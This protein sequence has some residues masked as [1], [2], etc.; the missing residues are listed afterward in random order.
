MWNMHP[1]WRKHSHRGSE[2]FW[3][4]TVWSSD[5]NFDRTTF[6][7]TYRPNVSFEMLFLVIHI[8]C[9]WMCIYS[10]RSSMTPAYLLVTPWENFVR[11][12]GSV[13]MHARE[14]CMIFH[15]FFL[16]I[17]TRNNQYFSPYSL[18]FSLILFTLG[19]QSNPSCNSQFVCLYIALTKPM[20]LPTLV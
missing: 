5:L 7:S 2:S 14:V 6:S 16:G 19:L 15:V 8:L 3:M 18:R 20:A 11:K 1:L 13:D 4:Q 9:Y 12:F 10:V 17:C